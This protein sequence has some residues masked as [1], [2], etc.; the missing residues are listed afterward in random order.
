MVARTVRDREVG[1]SNPL[2]PTTTFVLMT[3][4]TSD[5]VILCQR[6]IL[7]GKVQGVGFRYFILQ[8]A[9]RLGVKG[10][11][12]NLRDGRVECV[13]QAKR[14]VLRE[15]EARLNEGP[16]LGNVLSIEIQALIPGEYVDFSIEV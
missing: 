16:P 4:S 3:T 7:S 14:I 12:R 9:F 13:A 8:E 11:V 15:F 6:F 10:A 5:S 1:G 2:A